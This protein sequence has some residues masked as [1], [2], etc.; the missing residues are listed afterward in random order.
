MQVSVVDCEDCQCNPCVCIDAEGLECPHCNH[1]M[2]V[3]EAYIAGTPYLF[4]WNCVRTKRAF[5][6]R[7]Q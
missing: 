4:C 1:V 6:P 3:A 7:D 5:E 2:P